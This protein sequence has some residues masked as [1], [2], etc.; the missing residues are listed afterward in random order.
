MAFLHRMKSLLAQSGPDY[1][2]GCLLK[3][4]I[5]IY[6]WKIKT[7][8]DFTTKMF[9]K[10]Y[11]TFLQPPWSLSKT[12]N[13]SMIYVSRPNRIYK[14]ITRNKSTH[15]NASR[16]QRLEEIP[17]KAHWWQDNRLRLFLQ[18][19]HVLMKTEQHYY[20]GH[21]WSSISSS[22]TKDCAINIWHLKSWSVENHEKNHFLFYQFWPAKPSVLQKRSKRCSRLFWNLVTWNEWITTGK[23][24]TEDSLSL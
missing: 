12:Y 7:S 3:G 2:S 22:K 10:K 14:V 4:K 13:Y 1:K 15:G 11:S 17:W 16:L 8:C 24:N 5:K 6:E 21:L 23:L 9:S 19:F 18:T 20:H